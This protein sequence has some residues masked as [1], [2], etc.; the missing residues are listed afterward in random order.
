[1]CVLFTSILHDREY[2]KF[3]NASDIGISPL[4]K[5]MTFLLV[6]LFL[7][8]SMIVNATSSLG[9]DIFSC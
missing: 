9:M 1:M 2:Y 7:R 3:F 6:F 4:I 5:G 8:D